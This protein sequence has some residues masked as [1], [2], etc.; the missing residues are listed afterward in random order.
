M[1][2]CITDTDAQPVLEQLQ[3]GSSMTTRCGL[4]ADCGS[5]RHGTPFAVSPNFPSGAGT[6]SSFTGLRDRHESLSGWLHTEIFAAFLASSVSTFVGQ[7]FDVAM[8]EYLHTLHRP[9]W[10]L[11]IMAACVRCRAFSLSG[12]GGRDSTDQRAFTINVRLRAVV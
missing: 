1:S 8:A 10:A 7:H 12:K 3:S 4:I 11:R 6:P 2:S 5:A 9:A